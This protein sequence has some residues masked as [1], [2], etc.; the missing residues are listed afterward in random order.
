M[1]FISILAR[2]SSLAD[3]HFCIW[4][5]LILLQVFSMISSANCP[6]EPTTTTLKNLVMRASRNIEQLASFTAA[7]I[8]TFTF[9]SNS[10]VP[11]IS[12]IA[13]LLFSGSSNLSGQSEPLQPTF[14]RMT[15]GCLLMQRAAPV[16]KCLEQC[17]GRLLVPDDPLPWQAIAFFCSRFDAAGCCR[18][19]AK[20]LLV[21]DCS[22]A[23]MSKPQ[24]AN[25]FNRSL[26]EVNQAIKAW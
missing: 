6:L 25:T 10:G 8:G 17:S 11:R 9:R 3:N 12:A 15:S 1:G 24:A 22:M 7:L 23:A 19:L 2:L 13:F 18:A 16:E 20:S 26:V 14:P 5:S 4:N 21:L